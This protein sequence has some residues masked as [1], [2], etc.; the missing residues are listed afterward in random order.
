MTMVQSA[1]AIASGWDAWMWFGFLAQAVFAGRFL[2][3]WWATER[4]RRVVIIA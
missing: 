1:I 2:V 3:Q 4:A